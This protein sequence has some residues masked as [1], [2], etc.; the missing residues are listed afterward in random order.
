MPVTPRESDLL[1]QI[2]DLNRRIR[3]LETTSRMRANGQPGGTFRLAESDGTGVWL[4]WGETTLQDGVTP[5]FGFIVNGVDGDQPGLRSIEVN[6]YGLGLPG[7]H[8]TLTME[9]PGAGVV[10]NPTY[11]AVTSATMIGTFVTRFFLAHT[12]AI[13]IEVLWSTDVGTTGELRLE[14]A[15]IGGNVSNI[16]TL[17]AA[18]SGVAVFRWQHG[19]PVG[20]G[21]FIPEV[22][23][24]RTGGAGN[25]NIY[26]PSTCFMTA[27]Y[28]MSATVAGI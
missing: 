23:A 27:S 21:P 3:V 26:H 10:N 13:Q 28:I 17:P 19:Q 7:M 24:R 9:T 18:S 5:A 16:A 6:R 14:N 15:V 8:S 25:V 20:T 12:D 22:K 4:E 2:A 11:C 1:R